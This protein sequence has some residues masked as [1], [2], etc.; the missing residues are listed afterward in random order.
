MAGVQVKTPQ[1][2][3]WLPNNDLKTSTQEMMQTKFGS[4]VGLPHRR[5]R[6]E[7][8]PLLRKPLRLST[9]VRQASLS[10]GRIGAG[11]RKPTRE[12]SDQEPVPEATGE[13]EKPGSTGEPE[14]PESKILSREIVMEQLVSQMEMLDDQIAALQASMSSR[15]VGYGYTLEKKISDQK[16]LVRFIEVSIQAKRVF[17]ENDNFSDFRE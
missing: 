11:D 6:P 7:R 3:Q 12:L 14:R 1:C 2:C 5:H 15:K 9:H 8:R 16:R 4:I 13:L 17:F 10:S